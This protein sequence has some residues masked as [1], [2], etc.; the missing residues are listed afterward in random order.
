M[1]FR[2]NILKAVNGSCVA[3][4]FFPKKELFP[5]ISFPGSNASFR[6]SST[7]VNWEDASASSLKHAASSGSNWPDAQG[8]SGCVRLG[9]NLNSDE[10]FEQEKTELAEDE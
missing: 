10:F 6:N 5:K 4:G 1:P 8:A 3:Q 9:R 2:P 7:V